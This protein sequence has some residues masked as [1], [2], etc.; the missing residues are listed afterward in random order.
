MGTI[1]KRGTAQYQVKIRRKGYP[2]QTRTF[3][4]RPEAERWQRDVE[5]EMDRGLYIDRKSAEENTLADI[6]ARYKRDVV[7]GHKGAATE[8]FRINAIL[9][10]HKQLVET[11]IAALTSK[12]LAEYRDERLKAVT[13]PSVRR[14]LNIISAAINKA[15]REWGISIPQNPVELIERPDDSRGRERRFKGDEESRLL[16]A[17]DVETATPGGT[18]ARNTWLRPLVI[19][20]IETA[21]RRGEL[22]ALRW[23]DVSLD[24]MTA[25]LSD[26]KNGERRV[27]PLSSKALAVLRA[28]PQSKDGRVFPVSADAVKKGFE[29][30]CARAE[31]CDF[32]FHD[33]RHEAIS[34]LAQ[35]LPNIVE[36]SMV[37]GHKEIN[38]LKRYY[39]ASPTDLAKKLN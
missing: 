27:V 26:T 11:K 15:R 1:T 32:H 20:A 4:T 25:T 13:A 23:K 10:D 38:M 7:P 9:R 22:L 14:E 35:K 18:G 28:L 24:A 36:L 12:M 34:R 29:R 19:F 3:S 21:M 8:E 30:A 39:H 17:L 6:L 33:L 16:D 37:S 2:D 31:I 5:S